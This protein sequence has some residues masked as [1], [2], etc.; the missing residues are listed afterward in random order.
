MERNR[1]TFGFA[2]KW[3]FDRFFALVGLVVG[4]PLLLAVAVAVKV[5]SKGPVFF[6]QDRVGRHGKTFR[7][8][9]FRTMYDGSVGGTVTAAGDERVTPL[10]AW[11]RRTKIDSLPELFNVLVGQMSIVGPRPDVPG[12]ADQ[13]VGDD[14]RVLLLRPGMTGPASLKYYNE[15]ELLAAKPDPQRYNDEVL[16][17]DKVRINLDYLDNYTFLN[18]IAIIAKTIAKP[19]C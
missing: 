7:I 13:L 6:L 12:Y 11:L 5:S 16:F 8:I 15:E 2:L 14:R 19:F 4:S 10:G 17:P 1:R 9:K 18:D 3:C